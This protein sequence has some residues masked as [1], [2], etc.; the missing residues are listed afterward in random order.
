M[1]GATMRRPMIA[2]APFRQFVVVARAPLAIAVLIGL[3]AIGGT[4]VADALAYGRT[5]LADGQWWRALGGHFV[6]LGTAHAAL[7]LGGLLALLLLCPA[8]LGLLEWLRRVAFIALAISVL[9]YL[10]APSVDRYVGFSGV[11]HGLFL[12]GLLPMARAG[13]RVAMAGLV[14]LMAKLVFE[15]VAGPSVQQERLIGGHVV[16]LAHLFGTLAAFVYGFAF[17]SFRRGDKSQ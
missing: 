9:L 8:P 12:L 1:Q 3:L 6:H 7:N 11:L 13:D 16:T 5:A 15:Q 2:A 4:T 14:V 10:G 17:G